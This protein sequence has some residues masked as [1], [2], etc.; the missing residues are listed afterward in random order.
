MKRKR[1]ENK[2]KT[3]LKQEPHE[4]LV[5]DAKHNVEAHEHQGKQ[6]M[7]TGRVVE[8]DGGVFRQVAVLMEGCVDH[9]ED[10]LAEMASASRDAARAKDHVAPAVAM[11]EPVHDLQGNAVQGAQ[12]LTCFGGPAT[13]Y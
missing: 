5:K 13:F 8:L 1:R 3:V 10:A 9:D 11:H 4:S 6:A 7:V 12:G 2:T